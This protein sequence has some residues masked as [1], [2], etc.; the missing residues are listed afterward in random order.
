M[1]AQRF[2]LLWHPLSIVAGVGIVSVVISVLV[3]CRS[4]VAGQAFPRCCA[5]VRK[6]SFDRQIRRILVPTFRKSPVPVQERFAVHSRLA[7]AALTPI[8]KKLRDA[9]IPAGDGPK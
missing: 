2:R 4:T 8:R 7:L 9:D 5:S 6:H 1:M 3:S